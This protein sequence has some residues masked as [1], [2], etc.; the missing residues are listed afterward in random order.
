[1]AEEEEMPD[2][3]ALMALIQLALMEQRIRA[4]AAEAE[5]MVEMTPILALEALAVQVWL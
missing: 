2:I 3:K 1:M 5:A 4:E